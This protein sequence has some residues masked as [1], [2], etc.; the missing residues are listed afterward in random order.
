MKGIRFQCLG[1]RIFHCTKQLEDIL[2]N[3]E[4]DCLRYPD[5]EAKWN[6]MMADFSRDLEAPPVPGN[7]QWRFYFTT[8]GLEHFS[9]PLKVMR[10]FMT[11]Y[12]GDCGMLDDPGSRWKEIEKEIPE[13]NI[14]YRDPYQFAVEAKEE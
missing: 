7:A 3:T 5:D 4:Y 11:D 14:V 1:T 8:E 9:A 12:F 2:S 6:N 13:E 10:S